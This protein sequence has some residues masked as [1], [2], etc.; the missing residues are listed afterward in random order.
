MVTVVNG[1]SSRSARACW[2]TLADGDVD[3]L[4][5]W[6]VFDPDGDIVLTS[7]LRTDRYGVIEPTVLWPDIGMGHEG[8]G[9]WVQRG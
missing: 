9:R 2:S 7:Q 3:A 5:D 1:A 6:V 4:V 8:G